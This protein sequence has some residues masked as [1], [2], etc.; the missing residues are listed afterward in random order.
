[1]SMKTILPSSQ[2]VVCRPQQSRDKLWATSAYRTWNHPQTNSNKM[3]KDPKSTYLGLVQDKTE[4]E[5]EYKKAQEIIAE[6]KRVM[7]EH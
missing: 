3:T 1:M 7:K 6:N 4:L 2:K 5:A